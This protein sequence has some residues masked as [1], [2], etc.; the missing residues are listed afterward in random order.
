M[1]FG[2]VGV[3]S[4][5]VKTDTQALRDAVTVEGIMEHEREFQAIAD[6]NGDTRASGTPGYTESADHVEDQLTNAGYEVTRQPFEY[7]LFIENSDPILDVTSPDR[8]PYTPGET[9][10][11][12]F[13]TM[14]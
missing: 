7:E 13:A 14:S 2:A 6:A 5:A 9:P 3:A 1:A 8:P 12:D 10:E 11:D 4:A